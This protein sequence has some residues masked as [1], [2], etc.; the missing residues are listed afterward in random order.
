VVL[1]LV[2]SGRQ[3]DR[4]ERQEAADLFVLLAEEYAEHALAYSLCALEML[5]AHDRAM[6]LALHYA[7]Q[8]GRLEEVIPFAAA[9]VQ[10]NPTGAFVEAARVVAGELLAALAPAE[11]LEEVSVGEEDEALTGASLQRIIVKI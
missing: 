1:E 4:L 3:V 10:S 5:P 7:E 8:L 9:Y 2:R 6:Q 11:S